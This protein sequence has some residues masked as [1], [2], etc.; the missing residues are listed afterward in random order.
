MLTHE[1][2]TTKVLTVRLDDHVKKAASL[3]FLRKFSGIPVIDEAGKLAGMISEVDILRAIYPSYAQY[4]EDPT[5]LRDY[6]DLGRRYSTTA[7]LQVKEVY[8]KRL[9]TV[10]TETPLLKALSIM[11]SQRIRR[12]PVVDKEGRLIGIIS[13]GDIHQALFNKEFLIDKT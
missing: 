12:L 6:E 5:E 4:F 10:E 8:N 7:N 13:Q 9:I 1:V 2:M 3:I 11:L